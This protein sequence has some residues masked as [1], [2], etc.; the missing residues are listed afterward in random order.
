MF[1]IK[2]L[3]TLL[4]PTRAPDLQSLFFVNTNKLIPQK[5][6][7]NRITSYVYVGMTITL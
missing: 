5:I 3:P 6:Y 1:P 7:L 4:S 2:I